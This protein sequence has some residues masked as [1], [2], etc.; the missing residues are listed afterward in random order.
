MCSINS[1]YDSPTLLNLLAY[2]KLT[3]RNIKVSTNPTIGNK[4]GGKG[5]TKA[6]SHIF[7]NGNKT[8]TNIAKKNV[9]ICFHIIE[10]LCV[11]SEK[12]KFINDNS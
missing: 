1:L 12:Y 4:T 7:A 5:P 9:K 10:S 3:Y 6:T 11:H 2:P 8:I